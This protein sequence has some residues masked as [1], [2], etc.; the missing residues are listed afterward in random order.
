[1]VAEYVCY[2][3]KFSN[4]IYTACKL[5]VT[6]S[7]NYWAEFEKSREADIYYTKSKYKNKYTGSCTEHKEILCHGV[8]QNRR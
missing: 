4:M 7:V 6:S 5:W 8:E 2:D 1:M 3:S